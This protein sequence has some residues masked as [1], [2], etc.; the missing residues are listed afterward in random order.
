[1]WREPLT[2]KQILKKAGENLKG[3]DR[4]IDNIWIWTVN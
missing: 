3:H 4:A 1:M 2:A